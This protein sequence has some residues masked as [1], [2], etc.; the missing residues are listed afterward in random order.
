MPSLIPIVACAAVALV[1]WAGSGWLIARRVFAGSKLALALAPTLG[2]AVQNAIALALSLGLGFS[3]IV[4]V[5][6]TLAVVTAALVRPKGVGE[7]DASIPSSVFAW[8]ALLALVP[9]V[10]LLPKFASDGIQFAG[11]IFDHSKIALVAEIARSGVPPANPV[12]A[13][14]GGAGSVSYYFLWHFGAAELARLTGATAW[15]ADIASSWFSGF[16]SLLLVGGLALELGSRTSGAFLA[17]GFCCVASLRVALAW[18]V[19]QPQLDQVLR[20]QTGLAGWLLE[21]SWSPHHVMSAGC[22]VAAL[23]LMVRIAQRPSVT[24]TAVLACVASAGF[25]SSLWVGG[26]TFGLIGSS[27]AVLLIMSIE[28][29]KRR[30]FV[31]NALAA[32]AAAIALSFPLIIEQARSAQAHAG[33]F[34]I[35]ISPY[36]VF[37]TAVPAAVRFF[38]DAPAYWLIFLEVEL[39]IAFIIGG[40]S[41]WRLLRAKAQ[42][43]AATLTVRIATLA[44]AISLLGGWLL[45]SKL[46]T[47]NDLGWRAVLPAILVLNST[48]G[49]LVSDWLGARRWGPIAG[50][51]AL[52]LLA[53]P[54]TVRL[55]GSNFTGSAQSRSD[56]FADGPE[57]WAA[58]R[59]HASPEDR[60]ANDPLFL[61][62][63][64]PWPGN[65]SWAL[66]AD[67]RSCFAGNELA[68]ALTDLSVDQ[69]QAVSDLFIRVFAGEGTEGD[70]AELRR[71][72]GCRVALVTAEDGAW[73]HDPF[74]KS[75]LYRL[76][77][78][79]AG[80]WRIYV[81]ADQP[82]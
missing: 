6:A 53:A 40:I 31:A 78:A 75:A 47:N 11:P 12:F 42:T 29:A 33:A 65:L 5:A 32:A 51:A 20:R 79:S 68:L 67:R 63:L 9:T 3:S 27:S 69:R 13:E 48:A 77:E 2:W 4:T 43:T 54:D 44:A 25:Q 22:T 74:A 28:P 18:L 73:D 81:A 45:V 38:A 26:I 60:V 61:Q 14:G 23:L 41:L 24:L 70:I 56:I 37:G 59:R 58:V 66:L 62:N 82:E 80:K 35:Q 46:G 8:A 49:V 36:R 30:L 34:P 72:Y 52:L 17:I 76:A 19:G 10:A 64:T 39:P 55:I 16:A 57:M 71:Q 15:E 1:I 50:S 21:T 7:G